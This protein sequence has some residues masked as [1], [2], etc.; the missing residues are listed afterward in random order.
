[1][2]YFITCHNNLILSASKVP[3]MIF[4]TF[5]ISTT[6][7]Y[8]SFMRKTY[9]KVCSLFKIKKVK[10]CG[11]GDYEIKVQNEKIKRARV[12]IKRKLHLFGT[13]LKNNFCLAP[14]AA[15]MYAWE[16][17]HLKGGWEGG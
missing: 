9:S 15:S 1:M 10:H 6:C 8:N 4:I 17:I 7:R 5:R 14:P 11:G 12:D 3:G 2:F 16:K 13:E